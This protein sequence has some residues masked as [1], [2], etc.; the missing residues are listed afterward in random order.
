MPHICTLDE[1]CNLIIEGEEQGGGQQ[2]RTTS[3]LSL[4]RLFIELHF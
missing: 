2:T 3:C 4:N 1:A